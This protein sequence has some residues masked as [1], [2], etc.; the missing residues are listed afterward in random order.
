MEVKVVK[1]KRRK[2]TAGAR[3]VDGVLNI[4][5]PASLP[6]EKVKSLVRKFK[7]SFGKKK[8]LKG[9]D[10]LTKRA[11]KLSQK[12]FGGKLRFEIKWS[13]RQ[14]KVFGS[15]TSG[16]KNIRV[17]S[18]LAKMPGWVLDYVLVHELA[19]LLEPNHSQRFWK[20]VNQYQRAERARGYLM[21]RGIKEGG[22]D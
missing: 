18:R 12:Y 22:E 14:K 11:E 17:S 2:K 8:D 1:S 15:C 6:E 16:R 7:E 5:V 3:L 21:G 13:S 10:W 19:H 9:K 4:R 20:L